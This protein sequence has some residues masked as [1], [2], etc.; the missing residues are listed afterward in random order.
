M[1]PPKE[2]VSPP[3]EAAA[4]FKSCD[5]ADGA[6]VLTVRDGDERVGSVD[7]EWIAKNAALDAQMSGPLGNTMLTAHVGAGEVHMGGPLAERVPP[8]RVLKS[9]FLEI[10]GH[11]VALKAREVACLFQAALPNEWLNRLAAVE[12]DENSQTLSFRESKRTMTVNLPRA[13]I[14]PADAPYCAEVSWSSFLFFTRTLKWCITTRADPKS[15]RIAGLG[16][17]SLD[18]ERL[19]ER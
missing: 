4:L 3:A 5:H 1:G 18:W 7:L 19:D 13:R 12:R 2:P 9:D 17:Y 10:D 15:G 11:F 6:A 8:V 14:A 16:D